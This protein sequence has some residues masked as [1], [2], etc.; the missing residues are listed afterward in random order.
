MLHGLSQELQ[1]G[2]DMLSGYPQFVGCRHILDLD[3][4]GWLQREEA[5][6]GV[7]AVTSLGKTFDLLLR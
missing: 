5:I 6:R 7:Q 1:R 4:P 2:L 3:A